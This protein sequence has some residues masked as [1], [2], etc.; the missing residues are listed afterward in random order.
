MATGFRFRCY[1]T[2][3]QQAI[4][5]CWMGCQR[6]IYNAKVREDRYFRAFARK[7][8]AHVG[9]HVPLDQQYSQFKT[10]LTPW[11]NEVP[12]QI[13]RN[14]AVR[15]K[16]AYSR[17]F[18]KLGGRPTIQRET[19]RRSVWITS[20]LFRFIKQDNPASPYVLMLGKGRF[21]LGE[22]AYIA[23]RPHATPASIT[24]SVEGGKWFVSFCNT[25][26]LML[27]KP[28]DI[29]AELSQWSE[30]ELAAAAIGVDRGIV[31][32]VCASNGLRSDFSDTQKQ[33]MAKKE[34]NR[35][36]WQRRM[37]RR[38]KGSGG[39]H[40]AKR[41]V[42]QSYQYSKN[43][44]QDFAHQ[45]SHKLVDA[46]N[47]ASRLIVFEA[48]RVQ[49]MSKR[50]KAKQ[51]ESGRWL[52]NQASAKA[53]LNKRIL[54]SSWGKVLDFT[55]YKALRANKLVL[56]VPAHHTSQE[57][58]PCGYTHADNRP[59]QAE[60]LCQRCGFH[61]NADDNASRVIAK[62]GIAVILSGQFS[63]RANKKTMR[64]KLKVGMECSEPLPNQ[65]VTPSEIIVSRTQG[66]PCCAGI[67]DLGNPRLQA[68]R[69]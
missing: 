31:I 5:L 56:E 6:F 29:A 40:K 55:K 67:A 32:P 63:T 69:L 52:K 34:R 58:H 10:G 65:A 64:L 4:L 19:G 28:E 12:S 11:L 59:N 50:P 44:R 16:Q 24:I 51:D 42:A 35:S 38:S 30:V 57:C 13:L 26:A 21:P 7:S 27:P 53:G 18:Q 47:P 15:W 46:D 68:D 45:T 41:R 49:S 22:M 8:L 14:G 17:Y 39:W 37:A 43:V 33:R 25:D 3:Q 23:H 36:R 62:R 54:A 60:F 9:Q 1:P 61:A 66:K 48:L 2:K 20:E